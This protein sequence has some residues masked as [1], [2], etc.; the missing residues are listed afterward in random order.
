MKQEIN[1][2]TN[3]SKCKDFK[4]KV[5]IIS[6]KFHKDKVLNLMKFTKQELYQRI[7]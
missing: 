3:N 1:L 6:Y 5:N 4:E 2:L 7:K